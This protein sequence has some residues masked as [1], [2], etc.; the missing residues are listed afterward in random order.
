[1]S[2]VAEEV[3]PRS[4][5]GI[6]TIIDIV[7]KDADHVLLSKKFTF[8][9]PEGTYKAAQALGERLRYNRFENI[10]D[11]DCY[12]HVKFIVKNVKPMPGFNFIMNKLKELGIEVEVQYEPDRPNKPDTAT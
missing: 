3:L 11:K 2:K 8:W 12:K 6:Y 9:L 7:C 5:K 1:L 10:D 4:Q